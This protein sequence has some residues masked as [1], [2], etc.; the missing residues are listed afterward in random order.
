[1]RNKTYAEA[2]GPNMTNPAQPPPP[3]SPTAPIFLDTVAV[4]LVVECERGE[5]TGVGDGG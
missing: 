5:G 4:L 1:M 3:L 2:A